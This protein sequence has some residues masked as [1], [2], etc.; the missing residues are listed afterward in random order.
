[1]VRRVT[2]AICTRRREPRLR[3]DAA[4]LGDAVGGRA[5]GGSRRGAHPLH[6]AHGVARQHQVLQRP[7]HQELRGARVG[8]RPPHARR[9]L[10]LA[11][12]GVRLPRTGGHRHP[13]RLAEGRRL[14]LRRPP[15]GAAHGEGA[16]ARRRQRGGARPAALG[17]V[18]RAG[19]VDRRGVRP[20]A[21]QVPKRR[22]GDG[23]APPARHRLL[24][25][26]PRQEARHVR[27]GHADRRDPPLQ[28]RRP[29]GGRQRRRRRAISITAIAVAPPL[30]HH[31]TYCVNLSE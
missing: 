1:C 31:H 14:Q 23:A 4:G 8:P 13:P 29:A 22:G 18:R 11:H 19:G 2:E 9:P 24:R 10:L 27:G 15:A 5:G 30:I 21:P 16:H 12:Q 17:A 20:G 6:G 28:P 25:A 26:A 7:S 3:P